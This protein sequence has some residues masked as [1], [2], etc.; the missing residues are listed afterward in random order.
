[1]GVE[2]GQE[3]CFQFCFKKKICLM[4]DWPLPGQRPRSDLSDEEPP[5]M[6][7]EVKPQTFEWASHFAAKL[8]LKEFEG[9]LRN[10][11]PLDSNSVGE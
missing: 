10:V 4:T 2:Y 8:G 6:Q 5:R 1:M 9:R 11:K 3:T 7:D